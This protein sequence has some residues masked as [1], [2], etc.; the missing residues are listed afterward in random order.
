MAFNKDHVNCGVSELDYFSKKYIQNDISHGYFV[1]LTPRNTIIPNNPLVF[2][3]DASSDFVDLAR[4]QLKVVLSMRDADN[5]NL[6]QNAIAA[7][8]NNICSSLFSQVSVSLKGTTISHSDPNYS[9]RSYFENL[10]NYSDESKSTWMRQMGWFKDTAG[11]F[12]VNTNNGLIKRRDLFAGGSKVELITRLHTDIN[13]Q[14]LLIPSN[15]DI[16]Y[17]LT[18]SRPEFLIQSFVADKTYTVVIE[19]A[20]LL[21][22]KVKLY[23]QRALAFEKDIAKSPI[24]LPISYVKVNSHTIAQG[25]QSFEKN[26]LFSGRLPK[27]LIFALIPNESYNGS[28]AT[29]PYNF[30][31]CSLSSVQFLHNGIQIPTIALQPKYDTGNIFE[32]FNSV[33]KALGHEY[34]N[35]SNGIS[36]E[37]FAGGNAIYGINFS[38]N[39]TCAHDDG[40]EMGSIDVSITFA[41]PLVQTMSLILYT[42][43]PS[44]VIIDRYRNVLFDM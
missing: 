19:S 4:T 12:D 25:M 29:N 30:K 34:A 1:E 3:I 32:A 43:T 31:H 7:P 39:T 9:Y 27:I 36:K 8:V 21:V 35:F 14:P 24:R 2:Q 20:Q 44:D 16:K 22:R 18:P 17:I 23:P 13:F 10:L 40:V 5:A 41:T 6:D 11:S 42:M 38:S 26:S 15:L 28:F 33:A 37:D